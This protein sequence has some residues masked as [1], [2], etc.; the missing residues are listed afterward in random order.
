MKSWTVTTKAENKEYKRVDE[1]MESLLSVPHSA[2]KA[3][4]DTD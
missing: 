1:T 4:L 3:K 2:I